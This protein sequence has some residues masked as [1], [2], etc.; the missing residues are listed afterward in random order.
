M[1]KGIKED[2]G[3]GVYRFVSPQEADDIITSKMKTFARNN[4]KGSNVK[5][6]EGELNLRHSIILEYIC[7]QGLSREETARQISDR[8]SVNISTARRYVREAVESL[9][10]D[11]DNYTEE[12]RKM[13]LERLESMLQDCQE[14]GLM[15]QAL[16]IMDQIAKVQGMYLERKQVDLNNDTTITF[17]FN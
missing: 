1:D 14:R 17:N 15:D 16:K 4:Y 11:Y 3:N 6:T 7:H 2:L 13:H 9:T 5:W 10:R 12:V 8:W